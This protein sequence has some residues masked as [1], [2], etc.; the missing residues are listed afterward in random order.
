MD[1]TKPNKFA[2]VALVCNDD[3]TLYCSDYVLQLSPV[4]STFVG[5]DEREL[6]PPFAAT[7]MIAVLTW[8]MTKCIDKSLSNREEIISAA[9]YYGLPDMALK[10]KHYSRIDDKIFDKLLVNCKPT[11][12]AMIVYWYHNNPFS[13][14]L[15]VML[16]HRYIVPTGLKMPITQVLQLLNEYY[17][18]DMFNNI[19]LGEFCDDLKIADYKTFEMLVRPFKLILDSELHT[20]YISYTKGDITLSEIYKFRAREH[21]PVVFDKN[22][23]EFWI[24]VYVEGNSAPGDAFL[25]PN[26]RDQ[27]L[28]YVRLN[29]SIN[30]LRGKELLYAEAIY[31]YEYFITNHPI[32][33]HQVLMMYTVAKTDFERAR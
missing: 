3:V 12:P 22:S 27:W 14:W 2:N 33:K 7:T 30:C 9:D 4:L 18:A 28:M 19:K 24:R 13:S 31:M 29:S 8:L 21:Q 26:A 17:T 6:R 16:N 1:F 5:H 20:Q 23:R 11:T 32:R 10:V 15:M 25:P